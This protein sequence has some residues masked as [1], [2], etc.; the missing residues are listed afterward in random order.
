MQQTEILIFCMSAFIFDYRIQSSWA[1]VTSVLHKSVE[2]WLFSSSLL[3]GFVALPEFKYSRVA[4][5]VTAS[6]F[7]FFLKA[8]VRVFDHCHV[9]NSSLAKFLETRSPLFI[10]YLSIQTFIHSVT[11]KS[12]LSYKSGTKAAQYHLHVS[13][14]AL[15]S[16]CGSPSHIHAKSVEPNVIQTNLYWFNLTNECAANIHQPFSSCSLPMFDQSYSFCAI[17]SNGLLVGRHL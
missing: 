2:R 7:F 4:N 11:Y 5:L 9:E 3:E 1:S 17:C 8:C 13:C 12:H 14:L 16:H 10:L 6:K 15:C